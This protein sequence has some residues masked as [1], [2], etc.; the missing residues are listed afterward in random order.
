V[1]P[2]SNRNKEVVRWRA[3]KSASKNME[4]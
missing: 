1:S 4:I 2:N 3:G